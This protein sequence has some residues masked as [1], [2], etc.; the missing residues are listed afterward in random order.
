MSSS[1]CLVVVI[2]FAI[3]S[4]PIR[5][6]INAAV[7]TADATAAAVAVAVVRMI[8]LGAE[9]SLVDVAAEAAEAAAEEPL[10]R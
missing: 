4:A 8:R 6:R 10:G 5:S 7:G 9:M 2:H 1:L 3:E